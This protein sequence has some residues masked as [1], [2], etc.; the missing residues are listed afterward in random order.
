V[1]NNG[2]LSTPEMI[3]LTSASGI[4]M[5]AFI[6][7]AYDVVDTTERWVIIGLCVAVL[8]GLLVPLERARQRKERARQSRD[9]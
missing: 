9:A 1:T 5:G 7:R 3:A 8:V 2:H 4:L 6:I